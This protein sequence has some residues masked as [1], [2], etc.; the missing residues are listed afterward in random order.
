[1]V[2]AGIA[3]TTAATTMPVHAMHGTSRLIL[4]TQGRYSGRMEAALLTYRRVGNDYL[5]IATNEKNRAKPDWYLNLKEEPVVQ[6]EL[7]DA[8]FHARAT[9]PTGADRIRLL[10]V[11]SELSDGHGHAIPRDTAAVLLSPIC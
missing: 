3:Q 7:S 10:P 4:I 2:E 9:T 5:V 11:V 6:I 1:M 8:G